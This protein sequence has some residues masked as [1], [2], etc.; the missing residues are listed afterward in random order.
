MSLLRPWLSKQ[1]AEPDE[2]GWK[3]PPRK[4]AQRVTGHCRF[5]GPIDA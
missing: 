3:L 1:F 4:Y 5:F 2:A